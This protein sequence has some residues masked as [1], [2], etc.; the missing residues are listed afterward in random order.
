MARL[1]APLSDRTVSKL[2]KLP[3]MHAVGLPPGLYLC[4]SGGARSWILRYSLH[5]KRRDFG[6]GSFTVLSLA[7]ARDKAS[8]ARKLIA[9]GTD[10]IEAK[11]DR[12]AIAARAKTMRM[13][14]DEAAYK[15]LDA[16]GD[17][18][19]NPKH[20]QQWKNTLDTYASP[21]IG[22]MNISAVDTALVL[23]ILEPIWKTKNETA[24][25]LRGRIES[26]LD[27]A[28]VHGYREGEN[29]ARWKGHLDK[30]LPKP[31]RVQTVVHHAALPFS[32]ISVFMEQLRQQGGIAALA[33]EFTVLTACRSGEVRGAT[34]DEIDLAAQTWT[35]PEARMKAGKEHRVPLTDAA[36]AILQK[37]KDYSIGDRVFPGQKEGSPLSDMALTAVLRRMGQTVTAHG[38]RSSFRDWAGESTAYPREV[39]EHALAHQLADKAEAAYARGTLFDKRRRLMDDWARYCAIPA[40]VA[41]VHPIRGKGK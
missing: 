5:G 39:I 1:I 30:L 38:F 20:R 13:T 35:I 10:P 40:S 23:K 26:V 16:H 18:W 32:E 41:D 2:S 12:I 3:G 8:V 15:Y 37:V 4:V 14:F 9:E 17:S 25:R 31:S 33:L 29:P 19:K 24:S 27:W 7:E 22:K 11:K 6:L 36:L 34:W 28:K 21:V